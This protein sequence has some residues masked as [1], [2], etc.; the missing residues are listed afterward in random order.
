[1]RTR[2][3]KSM[4]IPIIVVAGLLATRSVLAQG[5][6]SENPLAS[7][8]GKLDQ[9]IDTLTPAT[10]GPVILSTGLALRHPGQ[11]A[12][13]LYANVGANPLTVA[14]SQR[15]RDG[16]ETAGWSEVVQPGAG[17]GH[18]TGGATSTVVR[19]E[20]SFEGVAGDIRAHLMIETQAVEPLLTLEA[21]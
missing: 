11:V 1:M 16:N 4:I 12:W 8:L 18:A 17:E 2:L 7:I 20:F 10:P 6:S 5:Q 14:I 21:R 3:S 15:D 19:C 13:C 9:I